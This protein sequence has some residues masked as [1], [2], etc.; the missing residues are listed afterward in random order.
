MP[1]CIRAANAAIL[2][3][4]H[5]LLITHAG[6]VKTLSGLNLLIVQELPNGSFNIY[7]EHTLPE[8]QHFAKRLKEDQE[9]NI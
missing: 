4:F 3:T 1:E 6:F 8:S 2:K 5:Q 7:P 9:G